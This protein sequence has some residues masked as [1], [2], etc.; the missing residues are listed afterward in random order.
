MVCGVVCGVWWCGVRRH[1]GLLLDAAMALVDMVT[2]G[3]CGI[4]LQRCGTSREGFRSSGGG[5]GLEWVDGVSF[6][7]RQ[8]AFDLV[9]TIWRKEVSHPPPAEMFVTF[10]EHFV[11][12]V[13][14][15]T[16]AAVDYVA[17]T[18][19]IPMLNC[20]CCGLL[21]TVC[22]RMGSWLMGSPYG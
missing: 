3:S 21:C 15:A 2:G 11:R 9:R 4:G 13:R 7:T 10:I 5:L 16:F 22:R 17:G 18:W 1:Y 12:T 6:D 20:V 14:Y 8:T 19:G